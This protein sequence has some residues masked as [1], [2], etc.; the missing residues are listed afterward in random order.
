MENFLKHSFFLK[1]NEE[2]FE[3]FFL[4]KENEESFEIFFF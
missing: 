3:T 1:E 4:W 2:S